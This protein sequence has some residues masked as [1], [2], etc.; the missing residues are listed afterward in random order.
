MPALVSRRDEVFLLFG[1][2]LTCFRCGAEMWV[3]LALAELDRQRADPDSFGDWPCDRCY[4]AT[5]R[6][7]DPG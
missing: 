4:D 2:R 3:E 5:G 6:V 1:Q 7:D